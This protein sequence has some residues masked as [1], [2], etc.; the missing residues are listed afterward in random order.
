L[1]ILYVKIKLQMVHNSNKLKHVFMHPEF[2]IS[3]STSWVHG[4]DSEV[5]ISNNKKN[6]LFGRRIPFPAK[7]DAL[8]LNKF[9]GIVG[10]EDGHAASSA[11][12]NLNLNCHVVNKQCTISGQKQGI[13][14]YVDTIFDI[15]SSWS[16]N[17]P[18]AMYIAQE[19]QLLSCKRLHLCPFDRD[20]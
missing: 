17:C 11:A 13:Y 10:T 14:V 5:P 4:R 6:G 8:Q 16:P 7:T 1:I 19:I 2:S 9:G 3:G 20:E 15:S 12:E 18:C